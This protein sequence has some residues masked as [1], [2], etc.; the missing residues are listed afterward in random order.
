MKS[1]EAARAKNAKLLVARYEIL[2]SIVQEEMDSVDD[3]AL[4]NSLFQ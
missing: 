1:I 4:I 3:E 2:L